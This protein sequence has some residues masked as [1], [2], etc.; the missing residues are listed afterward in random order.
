MGGTGGGGGEG[1]A[2]PAIG[3]KAMVAI[4]A[5][6]FVF[7]FSLL[8]FGLSLAGNWNEDDFFAR[9]RDAK[10][11]AGGPITPLPCLVRLITKTPHWAFGTAC[12]VQSLVSSV[13]K[14]LRRVGRNESIGRC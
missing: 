7:I 6:N 10:R 1:C 14:H 5:M 9:I 4:V 2:N 3:K 13:V 11:R 12:K 8:V